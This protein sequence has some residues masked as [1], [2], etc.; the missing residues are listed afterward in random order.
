MGVMMDMIQ[1]F[2][3]VAGAMGTVCA[4]VGLGACSGETAKDPVDPRLANKPETACVIEDGTAT[5]YQRDTTLNGKAVFYTPMVRS[6]GKLVR[7]GNVI[8]DFKRV[9]LGRAPEHMQ[10]GVTGTYSAPSWENIDQT[11]RHD[12]PARFAPR[13]KEEVAAVITGW[14]KGQPQG[15][16]YTIS[17]AGE[18]HVS[19]GYK[20]VPPAVIKYDLL[21]K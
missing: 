3:G 1:K 21:S 9:M 15:E 18:G 5:I 10:S 17:T 6:Q 16:C 19:T 7:Q 11:E 14:N 8:R 20:I 2:K 13:Y 4:A 12:T